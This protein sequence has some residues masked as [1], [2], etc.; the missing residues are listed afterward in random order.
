MTMNF[1]L[2]FFLLIAWVALASSRTALAADQIVTNT[3]PGQKITPAFLAPPLP[4]EQLKLAPELATTNGLE[5]TATVQLPS[6]LLMSITA[7]KSGAEASF[8]LHKVFFAADAAVEHA[9]R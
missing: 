2:L 8:G 1:R 4:A 7:T 9:S 3:L 6:A 5:T